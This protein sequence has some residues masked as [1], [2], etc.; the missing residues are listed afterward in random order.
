MA[1]GAMLGTSPP[2]IQLIN[3]ATSLPL[4]MPTLNFTEMTTAWDR[5]PSVGSLMYVQLRETF[6]ELEAF[7]SHTF[8]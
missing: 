6:A 3:Q 4:L 5:Y 1:P 8:A 2:E 7:F